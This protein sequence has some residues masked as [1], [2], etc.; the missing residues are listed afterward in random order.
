MKTPRKSHA[1]RPIDIEG[2]RRI[3]RYC[4]ERSFVGGKYYLGFLRPDWTGDKKHPMGFY[5]EDLAGNYG[6]TY[7]LMRDALRDF[8][9][10][11]AN[12]GNRG[13]TE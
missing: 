11:L 12:R 2:S 13:D 3:F 9:R 7:S 5:W 8:D 1:S 6:I 4:S 10:R